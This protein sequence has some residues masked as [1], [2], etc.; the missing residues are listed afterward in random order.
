MYIKMERFFSRFFGG[1]LWVLNFSMMTKIWWLKNEIILEYTCMYTVYS[2]E[3]TLRSIQKW[4][5][6]NFDN[7]FPTFFGEILEFWD[8]LW[9]PLSLVFGISEGFVTNRFGCRAYFETVMENFITWTR[10]QLNFITSNT[11]LF[12]YMI[13]IH[14]LKYL[15]AASRDLINVV[16]ES[17]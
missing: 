15:Y 16:L 5:N 13:L 12:I 11:N 14:S 9:E 4:R 3:Y 10:V 6:I 1:L 2:I 8:F 7:L 17:K